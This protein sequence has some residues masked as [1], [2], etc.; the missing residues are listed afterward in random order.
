MHPDLEQMI[1]L[2]R[3][4]L[5]L[6]RVR[7]ELDRLPR[8][9][10]GLAAVTA[11]AQAAVL[12][13]DEQLAKEDKQRRGLE[14]D[15]ADRKA[16][17]AR[18]RRQMDAATTA[19][20]VTAFEHEIGFLEREVSRMEDE[21]LESMERSETLTAERGRAA[22]D[23]AAAEARLERERVQ[24]AEVI[25]RDRGTAKRMEG[26]RAGVRRLI[27]EGSLAMYDRVAKSRGTALAEGVDGKCSACQ[28]M[29]RLQKWNDLRDRS[30]HET[31]MQ[32]ESCGRL[33]YWDPARD[34]P[35]RKAAEIPGK[36]EGR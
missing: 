7:E 29:V 27:G 14:S 2:Q 25:E 36:A 24:A 28:M 3:I 15:I 32:C 31:M 6:K 5:E 19:V 20:Q 10:A 23:F 17:A 34:A 18:A 8:Q 4:D 22:E 30:D 33:L 1:T 26:E 9:I 11:A 16:K 35:V 12:G 21:E 13:I